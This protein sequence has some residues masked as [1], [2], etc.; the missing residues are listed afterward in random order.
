MQCEDAISV[1]NSVASSSLTIREGTT[2]TFPRH[3]C[4]CFNFSV[5]KLYKIIPS[6]V[7]HN[8]TPIMIYGKGSTT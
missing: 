1:S 6:V 2:S 8:T 4:K 5:L 7:E 3:V